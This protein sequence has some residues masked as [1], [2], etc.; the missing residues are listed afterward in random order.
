MSSPAPLT[1]R[2]TSGITVELEAKPRS[3]DNLR[4]VIRLKPYK[5]HTV[6]DTLVCCY[7]NVAN[8][9]TG[10]FN[11]CDPWVLWIGTTAIELDSNTH[12]QQAQRWL[13]A[14]RAALQPT[15]E[16]RSA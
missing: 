8:C 14:Y 3:C 5:G 4:C 11:V 12:A 7:A 2:L 1:I 10:K 15:A 16:A 6:G 13:D 9:H